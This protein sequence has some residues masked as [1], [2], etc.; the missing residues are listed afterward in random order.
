[1]MDLTVLWAFVWDIVQISVG[2]H[3]LFPLCLFLIFTL[4]R[5]V[6]AGTRT[7]QDEGDYAVIVTAYEQTDSLPMVV[8]SILKARHSN[9]LIYVV[10]DKCDISSLKFTDERVIILRP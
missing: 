3:L 9:Y 5:P 10:A 7:D 1:M 2:V 8:D 6:R 4:K